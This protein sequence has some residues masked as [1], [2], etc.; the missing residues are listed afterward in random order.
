M[1]AMSGIQLTFVLPNY[2]LG[3]FLHSSKLL[4]TGEMLW[5]YV[6]A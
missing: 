1:Y 2:Y 3:F 6:L 4:G 5:Q